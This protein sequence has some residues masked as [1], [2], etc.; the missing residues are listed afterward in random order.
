MKVGI[1]TEIKNN[2][3]RVAATP[4]GVHELVRRGH[5]VLVQEGAGLGSSITDADYVEA[6]ATIVATAD[7]VWGAADLLLKV[8]EPILE[9][10]PRMRPGQTL[11]TYLHLAASRPCTDALVASGTTAIA[12]ETV[13]LP[14]RQL[15]LLQPMSE[16]AGR[17]STQV[18]AYH[19]MRAA[20]GRGILLGGVPGTPKAR[21]VVI[22]GGVA[23]E[24]AAANA[25]GMGADVTIIDLSIPRLRELEIRFG[26][27]VQTRV[28]SAYEI[29][30]QLK[31]ADLVI[32]SV[33]IPGAQ[34]PK[35]VTD[36]MVATMKK[37]SVLVDIAIDQGGCFEGS[38]ATSHDDPTFD[39]HDSVYYCVANMPGAVPETSTRALTNATLPYVIALAEKGWKR[40]LAE[41]PALALGLNVHDG[42]V[43]NSH[44]AAALDMPLTPVADVLAA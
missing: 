18:G 19:L 5:E 39:V 10:Y 26:G 20:G 24:H 35:L 44:V 17:L 1:P 12:Y 21:V 37:G 33:L 2:E 38:H 31:D 43:T 16:V 14:N 3:N 28:S 42:H 15:P 22:G 32:G 27:Q 30:A 13:Q 8:K 36:A 9:E 7:E 23:G 25:L 11:F 40:A 6:G 34:A 29:A 41:D 4:A